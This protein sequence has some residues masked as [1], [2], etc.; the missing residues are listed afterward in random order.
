MK[1]VC[2]CQSL[3]EAITNVQRAVSTKSNNPALEGILFKANANSLTLCGYDLELGITTTLPAEVLSEGS[4]VLSAKLISDIVRRLPAETVSIDTNEKLMTTIISGAVDFKI[5]G[6]SADEYPDIPSVKGDSSIIIKGEILS[7]MISQTLFAIAD[8]DIK[9]VQKGSLFE[10][11]SN[12]IKIISV[13]GYRLAM[14][15]ENLI[16]GR[17]EKLYHSGQKSCRSSQA[18]KRR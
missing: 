18:Y 15:T 3:T 2:N 10:I 1:I 14:R 13:D 11:E 9:P 4:V 8:S 7:S 12:I 5:I 17:K 6:M 16:C